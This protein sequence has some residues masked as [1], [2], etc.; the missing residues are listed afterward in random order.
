MYRNLGQRRRHL[1]APVGVGKIRIKKKEEKAQKTNK[2]E[3]IGEEKKTRNKVYVRNKVRWGVRF[4]YLFAL[5]Y[6]PPFI[7]MRGGFLPGID[8]TRVHLEKERIKSVTNKQGE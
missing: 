4:Y 5:W 3:E 8:P 1:R 7:P 2:K 6:K